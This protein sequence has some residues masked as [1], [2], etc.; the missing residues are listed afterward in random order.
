MRQRLLG[1]AVAAGVSVVLLLSP[2]GASGDVTWTRVG[3]GITQGVSGIAPAASGWVIVRDNKTSGQNRVALLSDA[4]VVTNLTWPGT[5]PSDLEAIDAVPAQAN[6]YAVVTSTGAGRIITISG[7]T[8]KVVRSFTLPAGRVENESFALTRF[9]TTTVAVWANRGS[10]TTPGRLFAAT[11]NPSTSAFGA[12]AQASVSVPFPTTN[13]RPI[14]DTKVLSDGR[15]VISSA[16]DN[17][18]NGPFDTALYAVGTV[19]LGSGRAQ[20]AIVAP[21][22]LGTYPGHKVEAIACKGSAG[23]LGTDDE[24]LG[25]WTAAG[26]FCD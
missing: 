3:T 17:G 25:G 26:T 14:S 24:N 5:A 1:K 16:S 20:L 2:A 13:V 9:G 21:V 22:S 8:L 15:I 7:T 18:N 19:R 6:R 4:H 11:F 12:V 23:I 10:T